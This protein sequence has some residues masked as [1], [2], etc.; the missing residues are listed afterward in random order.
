MKRLPSAGICHLCQG[1]FTKNTITRHLQNCLAAHES[2]RGKEQK[3][4]HLAVDGYGPY[5]LHVEMPGNATFADLDGFLRDTWLEC[6][7][8]LSLFLFK[9]ELLKSLGVKHEWDFDDDLPG[10]ELMDFE[11]AKV[12]TPKLAFGYEYDMG[13]TTSLRLKVVGIRVGK[14]AGREPVRL[15]ARNL[16]PEIPC[17]Q[18]GK[19]ARWADTENDVYYCAACG[20]KADNEEF[21]LP[22]VNSPRMGVCGYTGN[23]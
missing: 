13:S 12:L 19:P 3:L 6:C 10:E 20:K 23:E 17:G 16:P 2:S 21:F 4:F 1:K 8:H 22:V 15:L 9:P 11:I 5:W 7:G 14:W 18:C